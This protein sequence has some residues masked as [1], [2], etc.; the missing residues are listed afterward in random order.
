MRIKALINCLFERQKWRD[1]QSKFNDV[2]NKKASDV[3]FICI[4]FSCKPEQ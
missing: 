1:E 3:R 4:P 2:K